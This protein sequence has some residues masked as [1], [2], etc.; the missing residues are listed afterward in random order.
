MRAW[1]LIA[2]MLS[3]ACA[4]KEGDTDSGSTPFVEQLGL[5]PT[6][7]GVGT[8][9]DVE[10]DSSLAS[11]DVGDL[12]ADFGDGISVDA[13]RIDDAW[14]AQATITI[15]ANA[16]IGQRDVVLSGGGHEIEL[17]DA[18]KVVKESFEISRT[19]AKSGEYLELDLLG[20]HT[21]WVDGATWPHFGEDI[22]VIDFNVLSPTEAKAAISVS[23][24]AIAGWRDVVVSTGAEYT[25]L[26]GGLMVDRVGLA[27]TFS[28]AVMTQGEVVSFTI[29]GRGTDLTGTQPEI[30]FVGPHGPSRDITVQSLVIEDAEHA[31]GTLQ[32]S[33]AAA[34]GSRDV[35]FS[36]STGGALIS[37]AFEVDEGDW[38][39]TDVVPEV[40]INMNRVVNIE[41]GEIE[42]TAWASV[43][44]YL[45]LYPECPA[46]EE[47]D[48]KD[49]V[50]NDNDG[51]IDCDDQD[52]L[53]WCPDEFGYRPY[54][55]LAAWQIPGQGPHDPCPPVRTF[56]AGD[57]VWLESN[58]GVIELS[59]RDDTSNGGTV[60]Q[61]IGMT[62]EDYV[63]NTAYGLRT[64]GEPDGIP[65][66]SVEH[67][68]T[69]VPAD[70][71]WVTPDFSTG[72]TQSRAE[73]FTFS[74][75]PAG[76]R[77]EAGVPYRDH[78][79][80]FQL[81]ADVYGSDNRQGVI[82]A[83]LTDDGDT[84]I[85]SDELS[86][87]APGSARLQGVSWR[88]GPT[89]LIPGNDI[90]FQSVSQVFNTTNLILE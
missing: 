45:P 28:P 50:D 85:P 11:F 55:I 34:L 62:E 18:F 66:F 74:W 70:F 1:F 32:V 76:T 8:T 78:Y 38:S 47:L 67:V 81:F 88:K 69:T 41:T 36:S 19:R 17:S 84:T 43:A 29:E 4:S 5:H 68:I 60:Y 79:F 12:H 54:D 46:K 10:M 7:G 6:I 51:F 30:R 73:D 89:F 86:F 15:S 63:F 25:T 75:T 53:E 56:G 80:Y 14:R 13:L 20:T 49:G 83:I 59:R 44:F 71:S 2:L 87:L 16:Q 39:M 90:P 26:Y 72:I 9:I 3:T 82:G 27:A 22:E 31:Y 42:T 40:V 33:N 48:C 64:E 37:D 35:L 57:T 58:Q 52:C 21:A 77:S 61:A 24:R 23:T 65:A